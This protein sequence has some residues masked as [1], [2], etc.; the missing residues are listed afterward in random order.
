MKIASLFAAVAMGV[1]AAASPA[2]GQRMRSMLRS[3]L[4]SLVAL[5]PAVWTQA[6]GAQILNVASFG[7]GGTTPVLQVVSYFSTDDGVIYNADFNA[8]APIAIVFTIQGNL[9]GAASY[10]FGLPGGYTVTNATNSPFTAFEVGIE[11]ILSGAA[12]TSAGGDPTMFPD[13]TFAPPLNATE[14]TF[15]GPPGLR[16]GESLPLALTFTVPAYGGYQY[17]DLVLTPSVPEASTWAMML[18]GFAG[19]GFLGYRASSKG[20]APAA[21]G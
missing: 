2:R 9:S 19:L 14:V 21:A 20:A 1:G 17:V 7:S 15:S 5:I 18:A 3:M 11:T 8:I 6:A 12:I 13:E 10:Y 16:P 4:V